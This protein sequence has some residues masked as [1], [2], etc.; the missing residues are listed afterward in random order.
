MTTAK[1][2]LGKSRYPYWKQK[3]GELIRLEDVTDSHLDNTIRFLERIARLSYPEV[4][5]RAYSAYGFFQ[6]EMALDQMG[7]EIDALEDGGWEELLPSIYYN[8]LD[9]KERRAKMAA[10][11]KSKKVDRSKKKK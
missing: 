8:M 7:R 10:A 2:R 3:N 11:A 6:G 9:E 1:K 5:D 4:V